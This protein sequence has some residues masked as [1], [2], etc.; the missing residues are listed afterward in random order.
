MHRYTLAISTLM[1][2]IGAPLTAAP[3]AFEDFDQL[4]ASIA[5]VLAG[6]GGG[7][8]AMAI[9]RRIRLARCPEAPTIELATAATIVARCAS[10]GWRLRVPL[11]SASTDRG[12]G[13]I[14]I[15]RG[16]A[17]SISVS[18]DGFAVTSAATALDDGQRGLTV[19]VKQPTGA[20]V[21]ARVLGSGQV[22][23]GD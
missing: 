16:D 21:S 22:A 2:T 20:V 15:H 13:A 7:Q 23:I 18:G 4:E 10:L 11:A 5:R 17:V 14:A 1:L 12:M 3:P 9:D 8:Q 6:S 19:R